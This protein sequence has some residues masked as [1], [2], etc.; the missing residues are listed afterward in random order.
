LSVAFGRSGSSAG[1]K[2]AAAVQKEVAQEIDQLLRVIFTDLRKS[3]RLDLEAVERAT[4]AAMHR[5]GATV[6]KELLQKSRSEVARDVACHCG[7]QAHFHEMRPKQMLT[8]LGRI[9]IQRAYYVCGH[10]H[11]GQSPLDGEL[12]VEGTECSPGVRRMMALVGGDG[13]FE[14]GRRQIEELAGLE[15][16][17]KTIERHA[18]TIGEDIARR[19]ES[20]VQRAIQLDLPEVHVADIPVMYVEMDGTGVPVVASETE[21]RIGKTEGQSARTREAKLGCVF[22]QTAT[23]KEGWPVRDEDST[24]YTGAIE[25]ATVFGRRLYAEAHNRGW[26]RA[27]RKVVIGDGAIWIW[28]IADEHFPGATQIVDLYHARQHLWELSGKLFSS[29]PRRRQRWVQQHQ[30]K[31]DAG[32]IESLVKT[33]RAF[34]PP[35]DELANLLATEAEYFDRNAERM[36]YPK[37]RAD[38]LFVGSGVIEAGCKTVIGS[39]LK[40]SGMF[41]TVRGANAIIALRC[42]RLSHKFEDY[43]ESRRAA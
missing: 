13:P 16:T 27:K 4:R 21:G 29:D 34:T 17:S 20:E 19:E 30:K 38:H 2:T 11:D 7:Q 10:C 9:Y 15:V 43:W 14:H 35:T 6:L 42:N 24:T 18:E 33:L 25:I 41:W 22:T 12:D 8:V 40:Q 23:D 32:E 36:R 31:L 26:N 39:R 3:G 28:N 37:F 1:K 5:A